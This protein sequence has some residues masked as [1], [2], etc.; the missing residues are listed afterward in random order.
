MVMVPAEQLVGDL[1]YYWTASCKPVSHDTCRILPSWNSKLHAPLRA[2]GTTFESLFPAPSTGYLFRPE[3]VILREVASAKILSALGDKCIETRTQ[4]Q[5]WRSDQEGNADA[6]AAEQSLVW[7]SLA[8]YALAQFTETFKMMLGMAKGGEG[9]SR[10]SRARPLARRVDLLKGLLTALPIFNSVVGATQDVQISLLDNTE[11]YKSLQADIDRSKTLMGKSRKDRKDRQAAFLKDTKRYFEIQ[12]THFPCYER[13]PAGSEP[14]LR[15]TPLML[16]H[17]PGG[18]PG[19]KQ[20][21]LHGWDFPPMPQ[22]KVTLAFLVDHELVQSYISRVTALGDLSIIQDRVWPIYKAYLDEIESLREQISR[23]PF[24]DEE[25]ELRQQRARQIYQHLAESLQ[26]FDKEADVCM[27]RW[28]D[29]LDR[30]MEDLTRVGRTLDDDQQ[31]AMWHM[32]TRTTL[33]E[34]AAVVEGRE[35]IREA[36]KHFAPSSER[37]Q[38]EVFS[39]AFQAELERKHEALIRSWDEVRS[40]KLNA[41]YADEAFTFKDLLSEAGEAL[42]AGQDH[43]GSS[44]SSVT[45]VGPAGPGDRELPTEAAVGGNDESGA[46]H[47]EADLDGG[48]SAAA[49]EEVLT[50]TL[51]N[52]ALTLTQGAD[53]VQTPLQAHESPSDTSS[54]DGESVSTEDPHS[55]GVSVKGEQETTAIGE[56]TRPPQGDVPGSVDSV[57]HGI[58]PFSWNK[59]GHNIQPTHD[60][61]RSIRFG[62]FH[63]QADSEGRRG[64][65]SSSGDA[66]CPVYPATQGS[67][68]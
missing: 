41:R 45:M 7:N 39:D 38:D 21:K 22:G 43:S 50:Y 14:S 57:H 55:E 31:N 60:A 1:P 33:N 68:E 17:N 42:E 48:Q 30:C 19:E 36:A 13:L 26:R 58:Y 66:E 4:A 12:V 62:D 51:Q 34:V 65:L 8:K 11:L 10:I 52:L 5:L 24:T 40:N 9:D 63:S 18:M 44:G 28:K 15:W 6:D 56:E 20:E 47:D 2:R 61:L 37:R 32:T 46:S 16:S 25:I 54:T 29:A 35:K 27:D 59:S 53:T 67:G 23:P 49:G 64:P 3:V